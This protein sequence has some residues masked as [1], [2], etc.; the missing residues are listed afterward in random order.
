MHVMSKEHTVAFYSATPSPSVL[1]PLFAER[2]D[3]ERPMKA[4]S[5]KNCFLLSF[6]KKPEDSHNISYLFRDWASLISGNEQLEAKKETS[7]PRTSH[8]GR[9]GSALAVA[10]GL[11]LGQ[12]AQNPDYSP[13]NTQPLSLFKRP[14]PAEVV[15][16]I[17]KRYLKSVL[18]PSHGP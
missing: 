4:A 13:V 18:T 9:Y 15:V 6:D 8:R 17:P 14:L 16:L 5:Q 10:S 1:T 12:A 7:G 3:P 11:L 2:M